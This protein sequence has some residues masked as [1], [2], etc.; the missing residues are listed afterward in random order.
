MK[1]MGAPSCGIMAHQP[2]RVL[3]AVMA[4]KDARPSHDPPSAMPC[5]NRSTDNSTMAVTPSVA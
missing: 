4:N 5:E 2:R 1:P 3:G